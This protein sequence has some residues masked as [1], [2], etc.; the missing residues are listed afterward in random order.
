MTK[1]NKNKKK[2]KSL[3]SVGWCNKKPI[4]YPKNNCPSLRLAIAGPT[5]CKIHVP[6]LARS[7]HAY[8]HVPAQS[9]RDKLREINWKMRNE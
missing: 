1:K 7:E 3:R 5:P 2:K 4:S 9:Y 6:N 8:G